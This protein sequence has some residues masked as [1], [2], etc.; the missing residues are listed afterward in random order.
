MRKILLLA[1]FVLTQFIGVAA[2][3]DHQVKM[4][5]KGAKGVMVFEPDLVIAEPGDTVTFLATTKGHNVQSIKGMLPKGV[6]KIRTK[7][8]KP[9]T[10]KI[11]KPGFYGVKCTPHYSMGMIALIVSGDAGPTDAVKKVKH[12]GRA[13]K[14]FA[15]VIKA[16]EA[17]N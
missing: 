4:L 2:A 12:K 10:L 11:T 9:F 3:A 7:Y 14:R 13:K 17:L 6:K 16:Y 8:N 15:G 5:N 1:A